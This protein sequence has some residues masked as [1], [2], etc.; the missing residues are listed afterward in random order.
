MRLIDWIRKLFKTDPPPPPPIEP[1]PGEQPLLV[2]I[3][4]YR[5]R[6]GISKLLADGRLDVAAQT[7][8]DE[9]FRGTARPHDGAQQR[10]SKAGYGGYPWGEIV[11]QG[12]T[13]PAQ[14]VSSWI[15]SRGH[16]QNIE[17]PRFTLAGC[18]RTGNHWCVVFVSK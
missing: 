1:P 2:E 7:H 10:I 11:A 5:Q 3:N 4:A 9:L 8:T 6:V 14:A 16:R 18:G 15:S 13:S 17:N 12:Q